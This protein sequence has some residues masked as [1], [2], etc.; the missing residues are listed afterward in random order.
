MD[1]RLNYID[2]LRGLAV[3]GVL[4]VHTGAFVFSSGPIATITALGAKG[5][6]LFFFI[7]AYTIFL[8]YHHQVKSDPNP[9]RSFYIKRVFRIAPMYYL[10][11]IYYA[12]Y[13][14][15]IGQTNSAEG[16]ALNATFLHSL[17]PMYI[18]NVV[19]GGWSIGVEMSFYLLVPLLVFY[20]T[21]YKRAIYFVIICLLVRIL[22]LAVLNDNPFGYPANEWN[23]YLYW[24]LPNQ[25]TCFAFGILFYF[26]KTKY[27]SKSIIPWNTLWISGVFLVGIYLLLKLK[28]E[29]EWLNDDFLIMIIVFL[30][31]TYLS[32]NPNKFIVNNAMVNI[33]KYSYSIYL[34]HFAVLYFLEAGMFKSFHSSGSPVI[35]LILFISVLVITYLISS[36]T[37]RF[38]ELPMQKFAKNLTSNLKLVPAAVNP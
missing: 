14:A 11:I 1:K 10:G 6:Q 31:T 12:L 15:W 5:V 4:M 17:S 16:I 13:N 38:V 24:F 27:Q 26:F 8:S 28:S 35:F 2:A 19:P 18:N 30:L 9:I 29:F 23:H 25:L 7:S 21:S 32:V 34:V 37:F 22:F 36:L 3:L 20:V 33:G